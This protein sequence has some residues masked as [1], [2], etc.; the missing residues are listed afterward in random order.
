MFSLD[1][2]E[3]SNTQFVDEIEPLHEASWIAKYIQT[4][5]KPIFILRGALTEE[6]SRALLAELSQKFSPDYRGELIVEDATRIFCHS[7]VLRRLSE[8]GLDIRVA[9]AIRILALTANPYTPEY[10]CSS[11]HLLDV[12]AKD[13]SANCPPIIDVVSGY[14]YMM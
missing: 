2:G 1:D 14:T 13:L 6:L 7:V 12:L 8:R 3:N 4:S 9:N 10:L 5:Q 11:Q